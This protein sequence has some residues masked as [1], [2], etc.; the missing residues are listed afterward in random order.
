MFLLA[1]LIWNNLEAQI[2]IARLEDELQPD[3]FPKEI[4]SAFLVEKEYIDLPAEE[5]KLSLLCIDYLNLPI[6]TQ[7]PTEE[8]IL[9]GDYSFMDY[10]VLFW[11]P[12][13]EAGAISR[14]VSHNTQMSELQESLGV[15]IERHSK[16][17]GTRLTLAKRHSDKLDFFKDAPFY[18]QLEQA[19]A[20]TKQHLKQYI[21]PEKLVLDLY[22]I[23]IKVRHVLEQ[24]CLSATEESIWLGIEEKYGNKIIFSNAKD[25][26]ANFLRSVSPQAI[27]KR[28]I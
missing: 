25:S 5:L 26:I 27:H 13:L 10:A 11:L 2:S 1:K 16:L 7:E 4:N 12:H 8:N 9:L 28:S 18:D 15:F 24:T 3:R 23:V 14:S 6:F 19:V 20:S 17:N 22:D 21:Q